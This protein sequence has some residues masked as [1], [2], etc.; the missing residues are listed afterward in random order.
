[1]SLSANVDNLEAPK[2][3]MELQNLGS[4]A[5]VCV[6]VFYRSQS[7][8]RIPLAEWLG[9]HPVTSLKHLIGAEQYVSTPDLSLWAGGYLH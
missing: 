6:C 7:Q 3:Q 4:C 5:G 2:Y 1:M 8:A 9:I